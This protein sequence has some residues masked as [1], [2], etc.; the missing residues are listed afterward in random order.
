MSKPLLLIV[1]DQPTNIQILAGILQNEYQIK[2]ATSGK[3][4]IKICNKSPQP[5]L[6][7]L[8]IEMPE[9]NG[10]EVFNELKSKQLT[11]QIPVIF[12]TARVEDDDEEMGL[13]LG[14]V[15][16]ITKPVRPAIVKARIKNQITIKRQNDQLKRMALHDQ[17]TNLY[18]RHYL[19]ESASIKAARALRH[20]HHLSVAI[21]DLDHFKKIND[22]HGH[23]TGDIVLKSVANLLKSL[24]RRE[25]IVARLGGEEF[26]VV[27]DH[28]SGENAERKA[29]ELR[30]AIEQLNPKG[31]QISASFGVSELN[32]KG[33]SVDSLI[34]RSDKALYRAKDQGRNCVVLC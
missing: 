28:C 34:N 17:L 5:D 31:I 23:K 19:M 21:L 25:D 22:T 24:T 18:N 13:E 12:V 33:E 4:C 26:L 7:L 32:L 9:M 20:K 30:E 14:A 11:S 10:Y 15:D 2:V 8:D 16:Y 1:D 27:F 3:D 6:L 29:N